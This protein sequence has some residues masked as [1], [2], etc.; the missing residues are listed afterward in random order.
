MTTVRPVHRFTMKKGIVAPIGVAAIVLASVAVG[1]PEAQAADD[2]DQRGTD[3]VLGDWAWSSF[4]AWQST[5]TPPADPDSQDGEDNPL[6]LATIGE[7]GPG[8]WPGVY[9]REGE[10]GLTTETSA[11]VRAMPD[12]EGWAR[13]PGA[14]GERWVQDSP[15]KHEETGWVRTSPGDG[16]V[17]LAA[18]KVVDVKGIEGHWVNYNWTGGPVNAPAFPG[19]GW[20]RNNGNHNGHPQPTE[21]N[22]PGFTYQ[23]G[24]PGN[25][26]WFHW[27]FEGQVDEVSHT[28][29]RFA[30]DTPAVT[31]Q[32][33]RYE[34]EVMTEG[35]TE[36]RWSVYKR[37]FTPGEPAVEEPI[38]P[39]DPS[40][41][42]EPVEPVMP[43]QP[44][45][46]PLPHEPSVQNVASQQNP[47]T[48]HIMTTQPATRAG[49]SPAVPL[50]IDAGL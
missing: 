24:K 6:N 16:W 26:D 47:S 15:A 32:E 39:S 36:Y 43:S 9:A 19:G 30:K 17:Q 25:A 12:G 3:A 13:V 8:Q 7:G 33:F 37:T 11:W 40:D 10:G 14:D 41:P 45:V 50:S 38:D 20:H 29:Y 2:G 5:P 44:I 27:E 42:I 21:A 4:T 18:K 22:K 23:R 49:T 35:H 28:E 48:Q 34:R 46:S 1:L 31:H